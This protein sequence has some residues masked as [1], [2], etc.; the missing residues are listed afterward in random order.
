MLR[1]LIAST[2][3]RAAAAT[4]LALLSV[5]CE[6]KSFLDP[7]QV[8]RW[9]KDPLVVPI[10]DSLNL[11][12][13]ELDSQ[14]VGARDVRQEDTVDSETD[15]LV[16]PNDSVQVTINDL[17][18]PGTETTKTLRVSA[19][20]KMSLPLLP[21]PVQA[22]GL[23]EQQLE[24]AL[25]DAY[26]DA[27][28]LTNPNV[29]ASVVE[30][31]GRVYTVLGAV[32]GAGPYAIYD[33]DFRLLNALA[34][35]RD[36][37]ASTGIDYIYVVRKLDKAKAASTMTPATQ[38]ATAPGADPLAPRTDAGEI[39]PRKAQMLQTG[40]APAGSIVVVDGKEMVVTPPTAATAPSVPEAQAAAAAGQT[41]FTFN[42]PTEPTDREVIRVPYSKLK[43]GEM[44]YNIVIKAGDFIYVGQPTVGEYY[45]GGNVLAQG[46]YSLTGRKI[47]LKQ[48]IIAA[49]GLNEVAWPSR[50]DIVRRL[51]GDKE[52]FVRVDLD[53]IFSGQEPDLY[54][55]ADDQV[56]VGTNALAPFLGAIRNGFRLTYGFGFLY[57][58][59]F[60]TK[61]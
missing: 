57:D 7:A 23:T 47:T 60:N 6:T 29:T 53:K 1:S 25:S 15:Y 38:P 54:L 10:L 40:E 32:N 20:G 48:A 35:A 22:A 56:N 49:R 52:V 61:N 13:D 26:K 37:N 43:N 58:R 50:T 19:S 18:G 30:A 16:S 9:E 44:K 5:G 14:F 59:N 21:S 55:K 2:P 34:T 31:R 17:A 36:V 27:G 39:G 8:G 41:P 12:T 11:G 4:V 33:A 24:R 28:I 46:A 42:A 3:V 51:P 45:I